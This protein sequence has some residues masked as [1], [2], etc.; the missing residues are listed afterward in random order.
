MQLCREKGLSR[1]F[2]G[3]VGAKNIR[4][5]VPAPESIEICVC[6]LRLGGRALKK[7]IGWESFDMSIVQPCGNRDWGYNSGDQIQQKYHVS[8]QGMENSS[9]AVCSPSV[10]LDDKSSAI[11]VNPIWVF[12]LDRST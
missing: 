4:R 7:V 11:V 3:E 12:Q 2:Q 6:T 5:S 10:K 8:P 9:S 1:S